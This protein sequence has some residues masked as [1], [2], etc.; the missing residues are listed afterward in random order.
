MLKKA[1]QILNNKKYTECLS[2]IKNLEKDRKFCKH[3]MEHFLSVA[4]IAY[5]IT[6]EEGLKYSKD[7]IY[8][9]A[10]LHDIGRALEYKE[11]IPHNKAGVIISEEILK[12]TSFTSEEKE[13]ILNSICSHRDLNSDKLSEIIYKSD[14]L[15][16]NCF[17][18][19][20]KA[21][22]Y[23]QEDKRNYKINY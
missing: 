4:R 15:S 5:I 23:W 13:Q 22:C 18:C 12:E 19:S 6:L 20:A 7:L 1:N 3:D 10:L 14:K 11:N 16:R 2:E 9:I 8:S 21:D 17:D